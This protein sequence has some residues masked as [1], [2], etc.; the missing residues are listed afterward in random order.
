METKAPPTLATIGITTKKI[1]A[2]NSP[3]TM[4]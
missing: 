1:S 2:T 4:M 3:T